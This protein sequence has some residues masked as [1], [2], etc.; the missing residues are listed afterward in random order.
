MR[1]ESTLRIPLP[2]LSRLMKVPS[3]SY[4]KQCS[5]GCGHNIVDIRIAAGKKIPVIFAEQSIDDAE[6]KCS[7][8]RTLLPCRNEL[9][10]VKCAPGKPAEDEVEESL[11]EFVDARRNFNLR[12]K[13]TDI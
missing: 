5:T 13:K 10:M 12:K 4:I 1:R 3:G 11:S 6:N 8:E 2:L 7:Q 9:L